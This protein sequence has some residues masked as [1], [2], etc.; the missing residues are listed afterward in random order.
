MTAR[1]VVSA[2][3]DVAHA[4]HTTAARGASKPQKLRPAPS[5][6]CGQR[7]VRRGEGAFARPPRDVAAAGGSGAEHAFACRAF[8]RS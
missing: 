5:T 6:G 7:A 3:G 8:C 1:Q 4:R 2:T